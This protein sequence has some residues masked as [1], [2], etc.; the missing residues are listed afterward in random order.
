MKWLGTYALLV[1]VPL[2]ALAAILRAGSRLRAPLEVAGEWRV[3]VPGFPAG[4]AA[5]GPPRLVISQSG[6]HLSVTFD[7]S[8]LRGVLDGD[9]LTA[10][11]RE[12]WTPV[13][14]CYRGALVLRARVDTAARPLRMAGTVGMPRRRCP[15]LRF[16]AVRL[17]RGR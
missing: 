13:A 9:S 2:A 15:D 4:S 11:R 7:R 8:G 10:E 12:T 6:T 16:A 3:D 1:A 14:A 17:E 5:D